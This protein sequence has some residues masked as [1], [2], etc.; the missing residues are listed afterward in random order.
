MAKI[1]TGLLFYRDDK[2]PCAV[3]HA[4]SEATVKRII[5]DHITSLLSTKGVFKEDTSDE[6]FRW[7]RA[8]C[9]VHSEDQL[10]QCFAEDG[11][12]IC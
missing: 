4:Q 11:W 5:G 7:G 8:L 2:D 6:D 1:F 10:Q 3:V 12:T 9:D